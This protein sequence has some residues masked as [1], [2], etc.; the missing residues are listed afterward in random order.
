ME[1]RKALQAAQMPVNEEPPQSV[2]SVMVND[3]KPV[4]PWKSIKQ[5][6]EKKKE[7]PKTVKQ[8]LEPWQSMK[9]PMEN[10]QA[11]TTNNLADHHLP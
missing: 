4:E 6:M 2:D 10:N 8:E 9:M 11:A 1:K 5:E 3:E 7:S